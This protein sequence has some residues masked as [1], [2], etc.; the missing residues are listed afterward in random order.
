MKVILPKLEPWQQSIFNYYLD[1]PKGKWIVCKAVRQIG[2]SALAQILLIYSS[3][4]TSNS[5]SLS[6]SPVL[7]Q[8]R[9]MFEDIQRLVPDLIRKSNG[10][11]LDI[12]FINGSKI[13]FKSGEQA[14][15][16]RGITVKGGGICICDE[17]AYLKDEL[18]YSIVV[19]TTNVYNA[20]IFLF[21]T[22]RLKQGCFYNLYQKGFLNEGKIVS[23]DWTTYDTSKYLSKDTL[24]I[25]RQQM[26]KLSFQAEFLGEFI[27][28]QGTVFG[29]FKSCVGTYELQRAP[30][31]IGIDWCANTGNDSTAITVGQAIEGKVYIQKI[32][33]FNDKTTNETIDYIVDLV[34]RLRELT[35]DITI[36]CEK[37]SI[38]NV[39]FQLLVDRL[40]G[41]ADCNLFV[42]TNKSKERIIKQLIN[43]IEKKTIQLPN[44]PMLS[45]EL[46]AYECKANINGV[47][48][49]NAQEG[50]HDDRVMS[51][52]IAVNSVYQSI[53]FGY[54]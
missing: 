8:S 25:Y 43:C 2:K 21:S 41:V 10:S 3:L 52:A 7:S 37:N 4:T 35:R 30:I 45:V 19:P 36:T 24:E 48:T 20:N 51:L 46:S 54:E 42:T 11:S 33:T 27:D 39:F 6:I 47:L 44:D 5:V 28:G 16:I 40:E 23:F 18:F 1:N 38:G 12:T 14:D 9:K 32:H 53:D 26:P 17:A 31:F 15:S 29:D 34:W 50:F 49:Y 13:I 22:P